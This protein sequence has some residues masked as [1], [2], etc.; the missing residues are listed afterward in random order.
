[1]LLL[2]NYYKYH[3][4]RGVIIIATTKTISNASTITATAITTTSSIC[5]TTVL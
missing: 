4:S 5:T 1:M 3:R 2:L